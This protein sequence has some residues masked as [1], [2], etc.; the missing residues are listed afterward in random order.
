MAMGLGV[1]GVGLLMG[2]QS[3]SFGRKVFTSA[4]AEGE[5]DLLIIGCGTLG[6]RVGRIWK[7]NFPDAKVVGETKGNSRHESF[8]NHGITPRLVDSEEKGGESFPYVVFSATPSSS[9]DYVGSVKRAATFWDSKSKD[10][11]FVFTSSGGAYAEEDGGIVTENSATKDPSKS[12]RTKV[13]L[14]TE[15][16]ALDSDGSVIRLAGLYTLQ[17]GAHSYWLQRA[18]VSGSP[19]GLINLIHY[20]D[21]AD[22][23]VRALE[24]GE[25]ARGRIFLGSDNQPVTRQQIC[26]AAMRHPSYAAKFQM[27]T[28][29]AQFGSKGKKY[30]NSKTRE[31]L[32]WEPKYASFDEF[33]DQDAASA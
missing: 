30:D 15:Q 24:A 12:Q 2:Q 25:E 20:D 21:A 33:M 10:G 18:Q 6:E 26:E 16:A 1:A 8:K 29:T 4:A 27:P 14:D 5:K 3:T 17:R 32:N 23:V 28:F 7:K 19:D 9:S 13:L 22:L 31:A 11:A